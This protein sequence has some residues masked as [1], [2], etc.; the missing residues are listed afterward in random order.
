MKILK[1][2]DLEKYVANEREKLQRIHNKGEKI[3]PQLDLYFDMNFSANDFMKR[4]RSIFESLDLD[5][6]ELSIRISKE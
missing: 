5:I 4:I 3:L 1:N 2:K 6:Q